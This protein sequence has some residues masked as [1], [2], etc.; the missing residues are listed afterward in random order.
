MEKNKLET[1]VLEMYSSNYPINEI[2]L[3]LE[4]KANKVYEILKS[5]GITRISKFERLSD[6]YG[7][8]IESYKKNRKL[9]IVAREFNIS[10][11]LVSKVLKSHNIPIREYNK[12]TNENEIID[13]YKK[14]HIVRLVSEKFGVSNFKVLKILHKN[15]VRVSPIKYTDD[16][17]IK[18]YLEVKSFKITSKDL[19]ICISKISS[20]LQQNNIE[21][22]KFKRVDI[23]DVFGKLKIIKEVDNHISSGGYK[24]RKFLVMCEC[25]NMVEKTSTVLRI[26]RKKDCGCGY[27]KKL[28]NAE[29]KRKVKE[30]KKRLRQEQIM[31]RKIRCKQKEENKKP[32]F[33]YVIG[34]KKDRLTILSINNVNNKKIFTVQCE[35]GTI[36]NINGAAS[37]YSAKSCGCLQRE[38]AMIHGMS[39]KYGKWYHRWKG[40]IRRCYN[41]KSKAYKNYGGRGIKV[42]DRW[43]ESNGKGCENYYNDIHTIL[44][45]QPSD[46]HSLDRIDNNGNYTI[47]NLRWATNSEQSKNQRRFSKK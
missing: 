13:Y 14:T 42:C 40:M 24:V 12:S 22:Q 39:S 31:E 36:K 11:D 21:I 44:G 6:R 23:G 45:P 34:Y 35:C 5:R 26:G 9:S 29:L 3:R 43:L 25:G 7:D 20:V 28:E 17:I 19:G 4:I 2:A 18:H 1:I 41:E 37:F 8:I 10:G 38:R 27:R 33:K 46:E 16:E 30:E 15:N 47:E 32:V